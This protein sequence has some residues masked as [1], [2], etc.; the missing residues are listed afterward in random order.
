[1]VELRAHGNSEQRVALSGLA[2]DALPLKNARNDHQAIRREQGRQSG[3]NIVDATEAVA[4][5]LVLPPLGNSDLGEFRLHSSN[6]GV[7]L[8]CGCRLNLRYCVHHSAPGS[9][10]GSPV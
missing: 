2:F 8:W 1:E 4:L 10:L 3:V 7:D 9:L 5:L 6:L